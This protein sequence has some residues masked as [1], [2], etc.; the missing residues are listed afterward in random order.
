MLNRFKLAPKFTGVLLLVFIFGSS[1][2]GL[3]LSKALQHRAEARVTAEGVILMESMQAV[4]RYTDT[5]IRP[6]LEAQMQPEE[7]WAEVVPAYAATNVFEIFHAEGN[8]QDG[9]NYL[10]KQAVLDPT[11]PDDL[12]DEFETSL[13]QEFIERP[14][15]QKLSGFR[16]HPEQGLVFYSALPIQIQKSSCLECHSVPEAAPAAMLAQYGSANGFGWELNEIVGTQ[17]VYVPAEAIFQAT[18]RAFT[19]VM[20]VFLG[21]FVIALWCLNRMLK[22]LVIRPIQTLARVA[23]K[24]A[25]DDMQSQEKLNSLTGQRLAIVVNRKDELGQ[26]GHIFQTMVNE[27][28]GRQQWLHQQI[29]DLKAEI[30]EK[31]KIRDTGGVVEAEHYQNV[32]QKLKGIRNSRHDVERLIL[33]SRHL[34]QQGSEDPHLAEDQKEKG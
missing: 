34:R 20:G 24:L 7:F 32:H 10:Y 25:A 6:L 8:T 15:I 22:P 4:R 19:S 3:V 14:G 28:V 26:L 16:E 18:Q 31:R 23:Q 13:T 12:A 2:S 1:V 30:E 11:N 17:V 29:H 33:K 27:V 21:V 5:K 9:F